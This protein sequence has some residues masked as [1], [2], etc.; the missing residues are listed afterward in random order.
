[1]TLEPSDVRALTLKR[2]LLGYNPAAVRHLREDVAAS[3]EAVWRE[4]SQLLERIRVLEAVVARHEEL[5]RLLRAA[6]IAAETAAAELRA[7][8]RREAD[9]IVAEADAEARQI[10]RSALRQR[11]EVVGSVH[12]VK[13]L[14]QN[15]VGATQHDGGRGAAGPAPTAGQ[16]S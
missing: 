6:M 7:G 14:L 16:A 4:R 13:L 11:E 3:Y 12:R 10:L 15:S 8:A 1:M 9:T 2:G 5:E